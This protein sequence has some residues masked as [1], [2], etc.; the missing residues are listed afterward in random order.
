[1]AIKNAIARVSDNDLTSR[2]EAARALQRMLL[3]LDEAT[4]E[5]GEA[6]RHLSS[7]RD[8]KRDLLTLVE[9]LLDEATSVPAKPPTTGSSLPLTLGNASERTPTPLRPA[10]AGLDEPVLHVRLL[11]RLEVEIDGRPLPVWRS[12]RARQLFE[13]LLLN[14]REE[15]SR[16]RLMGIF[17]PDHSEDRAENNLSL[18]VMALRRHLEL[19]QAG[20]VHALIG[21]KAGCYFIDASRLRLDVDEF[22]AAVTEA[23]LA[24]TER[25]P[26]AASRSYDEAISLYRGDL[27]PSEL[28]EDWTVGRRQ[29]LQDL[30][31]DALQRRSGLARQA[32]DYDLS[33]RLS[34][35]LLELDPASESAHRRL[36]LDYLKT[37][38]RSRA[39][40]QADACRAALL[41]H[42]GAEPDAETRAVFKLLNST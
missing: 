11:G 26:G 9:Q 19:G 8:S 24:E 23:R 5:F 33:I 18:T 38:Q 3:S 15:I 16:H 29:G 17:W 1:M 2:R 31:S 22:E 12:R 40:Q 39:V 13:F 20:D 10:R 4:R 6:Q 25:Y 30:F 7:L 42:L 36:I 37:G 27:L 41:R 14:R 32:N 21:F 35:R 34:H 28:Y